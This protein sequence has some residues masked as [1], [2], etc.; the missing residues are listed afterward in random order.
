[1]NRFHKVSD[2]VLEQAKTQNENL[3]TN[4]SHK[5]WGGMFLQYLKEVEEEKPLSNKF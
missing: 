4:K 3:N 2:E 5:M 1:M